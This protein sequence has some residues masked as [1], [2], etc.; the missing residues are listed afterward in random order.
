MI[1]PVPASP[2][3]ATVSLSPPGEAA[4]TL[5]GEMAETLDFSALLALETKAGEAVAETAAT[6]AVPALPEQALA[7]EA[8]K[9]GKILP[10]GLPDASTA[11]SQA[12]DDTPETNPLEERVVVS[13]MAVAMAPAPLPPGGAP[14]EPPTEAAPA[15]RQLPAMAAHAAVTGRTQQPAV[16]QPSMIITGNLPQAGEAIP[17]TAATVLPGPAA[18]GTRKTAPMAVPSEEVQLDLA[19]LIAVQPRREPRLPGEGALTA[20][21]PAD[22]GIPPVLTSPASSALHGGL[23]GIQPL[24]PAVRPQDF[25]ALIDRLTAAR[26]AMVPQTVAVT[27]AHQDFGPVRLRFRSEDAGLSVAMTS[28]DPGF[29]RAAAAAPLPVLPASAADQSGVTP[30]RGE[31][32]QAHTGNSGSS[33]RD[34]MPDRRDGQP[35]PGQS[36]ASER[37]ADHADARRG[38]FA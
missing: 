12:E 38:I 36:S 17:A 14:A 35:Q 11:Q 32:G 37:P 24:Q 8:A 26:E 10:A 13:G 7:A 16:A 4:G 15:P 18:A 30:Q 25:S 1:Q 9:T 31:S 21:S 29:A 5:S 6:M 19:G 3:S 22:A 27:V 28:A 34:A 23:P 2:N 33:G 20:A